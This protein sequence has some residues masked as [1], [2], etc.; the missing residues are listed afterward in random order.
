M[1]DENAILEIYLLSTIMI[2]VNVYKT[3]KVGKRL[4]IFE[5]HSHFKGKYRLIVFNKPKIGELETFFC[6]INSN[7]IF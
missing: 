6:K 3:N 2:D 1:L 7:K 4:H 5:L